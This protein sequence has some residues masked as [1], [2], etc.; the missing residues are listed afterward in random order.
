M[1][2]IKIVTKQTDITKL[3]TLPDEH[4]LFV[5]PEAKSLAQIADLPLKDVLQARM[6]RRDS[7]PDTLKKTPLSADLASGARATWI[8]L[9]D[10]DSAFERQ[11]ALRKAVMALL[12]EQP[13]EITIVVIGTPEQRHRNAES[14]DLCRP[15]Q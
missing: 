13:K 4:L 6:K 5:L 3:A 7:K 11:T 8:M 14:G 10:K 2:P 9:S 15:A 1:N 12:D